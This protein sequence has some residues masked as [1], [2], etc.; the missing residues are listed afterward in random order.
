MCISFTFILTTDD[1]VNLAEIAG[2]KIWRDDKKINIVYSIPIQ[3]KALRCIYI[4]I[5]KKNI[6]ALNVLDM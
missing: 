4:H 6:L 1:T 2:L 3:L 5:K